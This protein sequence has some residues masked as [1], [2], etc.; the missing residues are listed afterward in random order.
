MIKEELKDIPGYENL[1]KANKNG[2]IY[3]CKYKKFLKPGDVGHGYLG[4]SLTKNKKAKTHKVHRLIALTFIENK[5]NLPQVNHKDEDKTNNC[6]DNL[7]WCTF[8]YNNNYGTRT[9]RV[10]IGHFKEVFKID[11]LNGNII[12][13]YNSAKQASILNNLDSSSIT[14]CCKGKRKSAGGYSWKYVKVGDN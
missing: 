13:R 6:V 5:N 4:V 1:Y 9:K 11:I 14:K 8:K 7:E 3:T 2:N 10:A 12:E